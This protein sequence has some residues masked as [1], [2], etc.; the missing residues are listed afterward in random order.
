MWQFSPKSLSEKSSIQVYYLFVILSVLFRLWLL[1]AYELYIHFSEH[2]GGLFISLAH[3]ILNGE[4]LGPY[5]YRTLI[6]G[7]IYPLFIALSYLLRIPLLFA[8]HL[9]YCL[10]CVV[11]AHAVGSRLK[12]RVHQFFV[13]FLL[14]FNPFAADYPLFYIPY[15]MGLYVPLVVFFFGTLIE[16]INPRKIS[17]I[18]SLRWSTYLGISYTLLWY[19][20]EESVWVVPSLLFGLLCFLLPLKEER[21]HFI[22][23]LAVVIIPFIVW[24]TGTLSLSLLNQHYYGVSHIIDIKSE[25]FSS[26]YGGILHIKKDNPKPR[27]VV[28]HKMRAQAYEVSPTLKKLYPYLDGKRRMSWQNSFF[29]WGLRRGLH[30][31]EFATNAQEVEEFWLKIGSELQQ[32]C[33]DGR[34]ECVRSKPS[35]R[36]LWHSSFNK[37]ALVEFWRIVR[38]ITEFNDPDITDK[39][40][41]S[42]GRTEMLWD[43]VVVTGE[44][45]VP[46]TRSVIEKYPNFHRSMKNRHTDILTDISNLYEIVVPV[47]FWLSLLAIFFMLGTEI[48]RGQ[49]AYDFIPVFTLLGGLLTLTLLLTFVSIT[50]WEISRPIHSAYPVV[51]M[52]IGCSMVVVEKKFG[53]I[54]KY[55]TWFIATLFVVA[56]IY[57]IVI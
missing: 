37:P 28:T 54:S 10:A 4:W 55:L 18:Y 11:F 23:R 19:T 47:L 46:K 20:R 7:P 33:D 39:Q 24:G 30:I 49:L 2:D 35:I 40:H 32:A 26:A 57:I 34:L 27:V 8:Q 15:R 52:F 43:Y 45:F 38:Q 51:L 5:D 53:F 56:S 25:G 16:T 29:M 9:L 42:K 36:P 1:G 13:F 6:K 31:G 48:F 17:L 22:K 50:V 14:L 21:L 12:N 3:H 41:V 44:V